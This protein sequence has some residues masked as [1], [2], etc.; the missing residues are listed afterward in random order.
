MRWRLGLVAIGQLL[1]VPLWH[2]ARDRVARRFANLDDRQLRRAIVHEMI[3]WQVGDVLAVA[4]RELAERNIRS[5]GDVRQA[6][7]IIRPSAELAEKKS[8]LERFLFDEVYR[9]PTVLAKRHERPTGPPRV[10][11][12]ARQPTRPAAGQSSPAW[13]SATASTA[14]WPTIWPG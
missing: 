9:H 5:V 3:D 2:E 14:P 6:G 10:V 12:R 13:P 8:G 11:R 1:E 4:Q 7:L